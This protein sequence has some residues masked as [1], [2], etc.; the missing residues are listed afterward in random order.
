MKPISPVINHICKRRNVKRVLQVGNRSD[1]LASIAGCYPNAEIT[2]LSG[3]EYLFQ[4]WSNYNKVTFNPN[5]FYLC[6]GID[7][8]IL[9]THQD[10]P[11]FLSCLAKDGIAIIEKSSSHL[12]KL[13]TAYLT[14]F[15]VHVKTDEK[16]VLC[17]LNDL[18]D[19]E[20]MIRRDTINELKEKIENNDKF[21]YVRYGD[22]DL[23]F[24][25]EEC[26][27][28]F[29]EA[30]NRKMSLELERGFLIED[31]NYL[32][33]CNFDVSPESKW[34]YFVKVKELA[35]KYRRQYKFQHV[36]PLFVEFL[37]DLKSFFDFTSVFRKRKCLYLGGKS[38][39]SSLLV[40]KTFGVKKA[41]ST[42]DRGAYNVIDSLVRQVADNYKK[43]DLIVVSL[44]Q[45]G[46]CIASRLW[47]A[48][49][50]DIT[51]IDVGCITNAIS[52]SYN[53]HFSLIKRQK[54]IEINTKEL[55]RM[56]ENE[57]N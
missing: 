48:G 7:L 18:N 2:V 3:D 21:Y 19:N 46:R 45:T 54:R 16:S 25:L 12:D 14:E 55:A 35:S 20:T 15:E 39:S 38:T 4:V 26:Y 32:I 57:T 28:I 47:Y 41:I 22:A 37:S 23:R 11:Y 1:S 33:G 36:Q 53:R 29:A 56:L 10:L 30:T 6:P 52:G 34:W 42:V 13:D 51:F 17:N 31:P 24:I 5:P 40:R 44:G 49:I 9:D 43:Y 50:R 8:M 27:S